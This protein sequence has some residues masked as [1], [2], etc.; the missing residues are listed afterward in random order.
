MLG[1]YGF[2]PLKAALAGQ[3]RDKLLA[4]LSKDFKGRLPTDAQPVARSL[5]VTKAHR[6][7]F[8]DD[9][10]HQANAEQFVDWLIENLSAFKGT[11]TIKASMITFAPVD[12]STIS[13]AWNGLCKVQVW[14]QQHDGGPI[15]KYIYL[16]LT[17]KQPTEENLHAG[18]WIEKAAVKRVKHAE[19]NHLLM[20]DIAEKAGLNPSALHDN[21][22]LDPKQ[23]ALNTGG[24]YFCDWNHD[25]YMDLLLTDLALPQG[26]VLYRGV[27]G[28]KFEDVTRAAGLDK[29][30]DGVGAIVDLDGD[31]WEDIFPCVWG[32]FGHTRSVEI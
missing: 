13:G 23:T 8:S 3:D 27:A 9:Q 21:W 30:Q 16:D 2:G 6:L 14:G 12:R 7:D 31:G 17:I 18:S 1:K 15:E 4:F 24:I 11:P 29:P 25:G 20:S 22:K 10:L 28:S 26:L 5:G 32:V 19:S